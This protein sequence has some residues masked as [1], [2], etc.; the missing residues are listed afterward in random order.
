MVVRSTPVNLSD[1][2]GLCS[3]QWK[4]V[5]VIKTRDISYIEVTHGQTATLI[6]HIDPSDA[7]VAGKNVTFSIGTMKGLG[8]KSHNR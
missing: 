4:A 6:A 8:A 2:N 5:K 1:P 7:C 3:G